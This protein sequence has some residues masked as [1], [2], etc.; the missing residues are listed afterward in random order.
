[1]YKC[2]PLFPG[3][4]LL[5][6]DIILLPWSSLI[7]TIDGINAHIYIYTY[8][9]LKSTLFDRQLAAE[10]HSSD[11]TRFQ[12]YI[13]ICVYLFVWVRCRIY[14]LEKLAPLLASL[15]FSTFFCSIDL[16]IPFYISPPL[17][18]FFTPFIFVL[19]KAAK[20]RIASWQTEHLNLSLLPFSRGSFFRQTH[21]YF[22][23]SYFLALSMTRFWSKYTKEIQ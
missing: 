8:I 14:A 22:L 23:R 18:S 9:A 11:L 15:L 19:F 7:K 1:M 10:L 16:T 2:T 3:P 21:V 4:P 17:D 20:T 12:I 5:Y 6:K 13:H